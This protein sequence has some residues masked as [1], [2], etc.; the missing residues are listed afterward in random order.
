MQNSEG[1]SAITNKQTTRP[2]TVPFDTE[3]ELS[4]RDAYD[5]V[6]IFSVIED[7]LAE[8][9][10]TTEERRND[11]RPELITQFSSTLEF[12]HFGPRGVEFAYI[13]LNCKKHTGLPYSLLDF[14]FF[15]FSVTASLVVLDKAT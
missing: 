4:A 14:L 1:G 10:Q 12:P 3:S 11:D 7:G 9:E 2:Y 8:D 6:E 5:N 15:F 13:Q